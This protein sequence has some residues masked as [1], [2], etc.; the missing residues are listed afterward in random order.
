[1]DILRR[2]EID[3]NW[4]Q[5]GNAWG[6]DLSPSEVFRPDCVWWFRSRRDARAFRALVDAGHDARRAAYIINSRGTQR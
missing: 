3:V 4:Q 6:V 1:M 5:H 2:S